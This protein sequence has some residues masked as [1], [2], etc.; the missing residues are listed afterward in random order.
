MERYVRS[1]LE[2]NTYECDSARTVRAHRVK[3]VATATWWTRYV[4]SQN[5]LQL[6]TLHLFRAQTKVE[7]TDNYIHPPYHVVEKTHF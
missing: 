5:A 2:A 3:L 4:T 7:K 6:Y 1:E